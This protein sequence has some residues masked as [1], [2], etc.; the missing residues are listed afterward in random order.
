[1]IGFSSRPTLL[2]ILA[3]LP[4]SPA[5]AHGLNVSVE[6]DTPG[7]LVTVA[8]YFEDNTPAQQAKVFVTEVDSTP[9]VH[10]TTDDRG[11]WAFAR[12]APGRYRILVDAG[13]G[14]RVHADLTIATDPALSAGIDTPSRAEFTRFRWLGVLGGVGFLGLFAGVAWLVR[15]RR[16]RSSPL[17]TS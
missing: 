10:G 16:A 11:R 4:A 17:V 2:A 12:P 1:M 6:P 5:M 3:L 9:V 13:N 8:A 7:A 15:R 14:H